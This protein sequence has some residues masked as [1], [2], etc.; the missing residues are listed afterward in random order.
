MKY[1]S[2]FW[3]IFGKNQPQEHQKPAP[4]GLTY[5]FTGAGDGIRTRDLLITKKLEAPILSLSS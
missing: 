2:E 5:D 4:Q 1:K 3:Q